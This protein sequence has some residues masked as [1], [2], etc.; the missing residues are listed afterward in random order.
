MQDSRLI[1]STSG[2]PDPS[3]PGMS[4]QV[5]VSV[6][7][8]ANQEEITSPIPQA[9]ESSDKVSIIRDIIKLPE[10]TPS[11][12]T[13]QGM[14]QSKKI[15]KSQQNIRVQ[16]KGKFYRSQTIVDRYQTLLLMSCED[17]G[18]EDAGN[19][20]LICCQIE[21]RTIRFGTGKF[22]LTLI[23]QRL[24]TIAPIISCQSE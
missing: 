8:T 23:T 13:R 5:N 20:C 6:V 22:C 1:S 4:K 17:D 12:P 3:V 15:K 19:L 21:K 18:T 24:T 14:P 10:K 16:E 9:R 2:H 7:D 11:F